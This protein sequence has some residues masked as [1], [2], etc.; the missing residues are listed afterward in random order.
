[1][2][3]DYYPAF[4]A[5]K[6]TELA[7]SLVVTHKATGE[8]VTRVAQANRAVVEQA[9]TA[10]TEAFEKTRRLGG[11]QRQAVLQHVAQ[12][13]SERHEELA[14]A[15]AMEAGK[16][17]RD[18]RGEVTRLLDTFR[19]GAEEAVRITGEWIPLDISPRAAGVQGIVRRFP[20]GPCAL[21]TP[22]NFPMNLVAHKVA[23]AIAAGCTW[24]LKPAST[25][26][27]GALILGEILAE[28][29]LPAGAFSILP[30]SAAEAEPLVTDERIKLLSF[31]GSPDVGWRLKTQAGKKRV[32]LELGGNAACI[33]DDGA[34]LDYAADRITLGAFY[35]SGQSCISVQRVLAH[36][37]IYDALRD[38]LVDRARKCKAG[39]PLDENTFLGPLI[40]EDD[41]RRVEEWVDEAVA[42]GARVLCGAKRDGAFYAATY[43]ENVDPQQKVSSVE[44]FG[45]VATLQP[46]DVFAEAVRIAND[47]RYGLQCG[48]FTPRIDHAFYA[49]EEL[50]VGGV[51][52]N[53]MP[54]LRVD[55]MPYGGVRDSGT[56]REGV[57]YAI[58]EM[59]ERKL[60]LLKQV[61]ELRD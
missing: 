24:V 47:S 48:I 13:V 14:E 6:P 41:A 50:D 55:S 28:T 49:Y 60:L 25:T 15:L 59:T 52:I 11:F 9:I 31:T 46:F 51:V 36:R 57:R 58:E 19:I 8:V 4:V 5:G 61:G 17:I 26:P 18:A 29:D 23:P 54:S 56:G 37:N 35:Q 33:V 40:T 27:V 21:I 1:M 20:L 45:P 38:R 43:L 3:R 10:A 16:P 7:D 30:C 42:A 22:F 34:D 53:D 44:V 2:L 12:R 39:D 32:A